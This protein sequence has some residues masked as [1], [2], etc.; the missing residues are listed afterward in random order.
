MALLK[1][2]YMYYKLID[3]KDNNVDERFH[4]AVPPEKITVVNDKGEPVEDRFLGPF[5]EGASVNVTCVST[6]GKYH[7]ARCQSSN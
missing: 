5:N 1:L 7:N 4:Y 2:L 6:G 3:I